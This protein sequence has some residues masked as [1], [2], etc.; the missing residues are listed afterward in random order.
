MVQRLLGMGDILSIIEKTEETI[1]QEEALETAKRM[2]KGKFDLEDFLNTLKQ[3]KKMGPL[4][5]LLKLIPGASK[6]G[7]NNV[8]VDP[9]ALSRV[10]AIILSMTPAERKNPDILKSSRKIRISKGSSTT[11]EEVNRLLKQFEQM[12]EMMKRMGNGNM[13]L[14]F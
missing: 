14:P 6:M 1:N 12:K 7:L 4:E 8:N 9:K 2:K 13:K 11:V 5:N 3:I 10:E